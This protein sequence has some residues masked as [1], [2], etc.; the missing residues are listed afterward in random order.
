MKNHTP[1]S[2]YNLMVCCGIQVQERNEQFTSGVL[3][4]CQ[5]QLLLLSLANATARTST[6]QPAASTVI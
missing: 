6:K 3:Q 5:A 4:S 2:Y 1:A